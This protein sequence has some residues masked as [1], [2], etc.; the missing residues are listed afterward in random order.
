MEA[1]NAKAWKRIAKVYADENKRMRRDISTLCEIFSS[2]YDH[3]SER[4][5]H[6][7]V[8]SILKV[9]EGPDD[10]ALL[11]GFLRAVT[12]TSMVEGLEEQSDS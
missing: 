7:L 8:E 10:P 2:D 11:S 3:W 1:K 9:L 5:T 12:I 6:H 4:K